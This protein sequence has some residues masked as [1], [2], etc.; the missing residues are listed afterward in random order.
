[1]SNINHIFLDAEITAQEWHLSQFIFAISFP[2]IDLSNVFFSPKII[3]F[4][5]GTT[6]NV[7]GLSV[8]ATWACTAVR[9]HPRRTA[10][11]AM[12][13]RSPWWSRLHRAAW[14]HWAACPAHPAVSGKRVPT[15]GTRVS[16]MSLAFE[17]L[18]LE[19]AAFPTMFFFI[20]KRSLTDH[21]TTQHAVTIRNTRRTAHHNARSK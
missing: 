8:C 19:R 11:A 12:S 5:S 10:P 9:T 7:V 16:G 14:S 6:D 13:W 4:V 15:A 20:F 17:L 18:V 21:R 1:M 3:D 2:L